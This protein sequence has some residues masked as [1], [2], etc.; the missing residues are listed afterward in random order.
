MRLFRIRSTAKSVHTYFS[1]STPPTTTEG[2]RTQEHQG[3]F[4]RGCVPV[5]ARSLKKPKKEAAANDIKGREEGK[6]DKSSIFP[7][8]R[9]A[10]LGG[11]KNFR[12][13]RQETR[14]E[15]LYRLSCRASVPTKSVFEGHFL[16][17]DPFVREKPRR[18]TWA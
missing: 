6:N 8:H 14:R 2:R 11:R 3:R 5:A 13:G 15:L 7:S 16:S 10:L 4:S 17:V 9:F 1:P 12:E 18:S